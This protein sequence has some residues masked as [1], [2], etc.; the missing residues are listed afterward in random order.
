MLRNKPLTQA[1]AWG[2]R[3]CEGEFRRPCHRRRYMDIPRKG[4]MRR[5]PSG[6]APAILAFR[7]RPSSPSVK[8]IL[9]ERYGAPDDLVLA[10]I[11][12]PVAGPG[13]VVAKVVAVG[14]NFFDTLIIAGKYQTKPPFPFSPGGELAGVVESTGAGVAEFKPGDRVMGYT[15]FNAARERTAVAARQLVRIS[16]DLDSD[17]AAAL[18]VTYGT[19]Y[20]AL[21]HRARMRPNETLAVLGASGGVGLAAVELGRVMGARVIACASSADKLA[22]ARA[23]G[24]HET[25]DYV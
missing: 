15:G 4:T 9:C 24:A 1:L 23:H 25:V 19:A 16:A 12:E 17:R 20:H 7:P 2:I 22:F 13:E 11:P 10:E 3:Q 21:A 8:A 14:L 18:T 6:A 5:R